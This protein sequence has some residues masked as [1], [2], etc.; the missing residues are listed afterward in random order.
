[1]SILRTNFAAEAALHNAELDN[2]VVV[3]PAS[4]AMQAREETA[5]DERVLPQE[6][7]GV[8]LAVRRTREVSSL[9]GSEGNDWHRLEVIVWGNVQDD[10]ADS[11]L[12]DSASS[13]HVSVGYLA[14]VVDDLL[15]GYL[16]GNDGVSSIRKIEGDRVPSPIAKMPSL[17]QIKLVYQVLQ[18]VRR[19]GA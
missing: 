15:R 5:L 12:Y 18:R 10:V 19:W 11:T 6:S 2:V 9:G 13:G 1:M 4:V 17:H 8:W 16:V 14:Q 7:S 3:S